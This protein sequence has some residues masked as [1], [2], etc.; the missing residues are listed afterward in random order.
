MNKCRLW[1]DGDTALTITGQLALTAV[2]PR[3]QDFTL[4]M[5]RHG[6]TSR[7]PLHQLSTTELIKQ[8]TDF[9]LT[10]IEI[11]PY[12]LYPTWKPNR[13]GQ[14]ADTNAFQSVTVTNDLII[15]Q[16]NAQGTPQEV[17]ERNNPYEVIGQTELLSG[18]CL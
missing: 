5:Q 14:P 7:D 10:M 4:Q 17:F 9:P 13:Y 16:I 8:L 12:T 2:D 11:G 18:L 1:D 3:T 15:L 6:L